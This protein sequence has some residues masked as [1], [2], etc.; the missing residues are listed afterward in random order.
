[1]KAIA[2]NFPESD[3]PYSQLIDQTTEACVIAS[4]AAAIAAESIATQSEILLESLR[5]HG[6]RLDLLEMEIGAGV[7]AALT[8]IDERETHQLLACLKLATGLKEISGLLVCTAT[9][10]QAVGI[11][12]PQDTRDLIRMA[13][14]LEKMLTHLGGAFGSRDI[15]KAAAVPPCDSEID[16]LHYRLAKRHLTGSDDAPAVSLANWLKEAGDQAKVLAEGIC[17]FASGDRAFQ[18]LITR[19]KPVEREFLN[20]LQR[21]ESSGCRADRGSA[22]DRTIRIQI[23]PRFRTSRDIAR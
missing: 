23:Q 22:R 10:A 7:A 2:V 11:L 8:G 6:K 20:W 3:F 1:M 18:D 15:T 9:Q 17:H 5:D 21:R 19:N 16:R 14:I 12:A 4:E 13:A